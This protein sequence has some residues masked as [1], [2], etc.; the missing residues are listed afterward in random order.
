M[1]LGTTA[2]PRWARE[3]VQPFA[4]DDALGCATIP[5]TYSPEITNVEYLVLEGQPQP[6]AAGYCFPDS[7]I[8]FTVEFRGAF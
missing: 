8:S 7:E 3:T 4:G 5:L 1:P 6:G 2:C